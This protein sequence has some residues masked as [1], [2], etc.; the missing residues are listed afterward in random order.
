MALSPEEASVE[1]VDA[2]DSKERTM[3]ERTLEGLDL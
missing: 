2:R 1:A 3:N